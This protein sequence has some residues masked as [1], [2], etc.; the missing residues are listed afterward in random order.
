MDK[1]F[2]D[3]SEWYDEDKAAIEEVAWN[4]IQE[5]RGNLAQVQ[6][7]ID[8]LGTKSIIEVGC[9]SG[10]I[11]VHLSKEIDYVGLDN[12]PTFLRWA[13]SKNHKSRIFVQND[14][15]KTDTA[16]LSKNNLSGEYD[17]VASFA[18]LKHFGLHEWDEIV[19]RVLAFSGHGCIEIVTREAGDLDNGLTF[20]HTHV[21]SDHMAAA[22]TAAGHDIVR[23]KEMWKGLA[24]DG[25]DIAVKVVVTEK[26]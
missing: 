10:L 12:N 7:C 25:S 3:I 23:V 9:G 6:E 13:R 14:L 20:H 1:Q 4:T 16:W 19:G 18:F 24:D 17:L 2:P 21:T 5:Y 11:P 26:V 8:I 22:I 15:R